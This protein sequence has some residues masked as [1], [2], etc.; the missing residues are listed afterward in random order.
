VLASHQVDSFPV[1]MA[2]ALSDRVYFA[3]WERQAMVI[4]VTALAASIV[5]VACFTVLVRVL[6]RRE[7]HLQ[8]TERLRKAAEAANRAKTEFLATMSHEIRTPM[9]GILGTAELLARSVTD[10][11]ERQLARTLLRSG[12]SLLGIINDILDL[13][14]IEAGELQVLQ[15]PFSPGQLVREVCEL[16]MTSAHNKGL[17]LQVHIDEGVPP[18]VMGDVQRVRQIMG[19]L[20]SNAIKFSDAGV[21]ATRLMRHAG[22]GGSE[23]LRFEVQDQGVGI[24]PEARDRL[25]QPFVQADSTVERRF[26]GTGLGLTISRRLAHLMGGRIDFESTP[27]EGSRF[28]FEADFEITDEPVAEPPH[29]ELPELRYAHSGAMPLEPVCPVS[30]VVEEEQ[31]DRQPHVLVVEDNAVNAL[32]VEAQLQSLD[33]RCDIAFDGEDALV[34][35]QKNGYDIVLMDCMLPKLSGYEVTSRWRSQEQAHGLRRLPIIALTANALATSAQDAIRSG[36][37]DFLTKP[38]T[39]DKLAAALRR[40][41]P[42]AVH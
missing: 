23:R 2:V 13:S 17:T 40:W 6:R 33:C 38:C 32:V 21:I 10:D 25:F 8:E 31:P 30:P 20:V 41:L 16:F 26:G 37:D 42:A 14:K 1:H 11:R 35:L 18:A 29:D 12:R 34:H 22:T 9:N 15:A 24:A 39:V 28:W 27:G 4:T 5:L 3:A 19:N 36:M 7:Q